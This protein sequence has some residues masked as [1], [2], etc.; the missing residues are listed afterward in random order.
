MINYILDRL[1]ETSTWRGIVGVLTGLGVK[2]RPDL[3]ESIIAAGIALI[4]V[5]NI[6]RK[7]KSVPAASV[8]TQKP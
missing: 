1:N 5:V 4:G 3:A 6:F 2:V 8:D 7:E